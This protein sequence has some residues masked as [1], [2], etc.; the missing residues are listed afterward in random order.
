M[1]GTPRTDAAAKTRGPYKREHFDQNMP[2]RFLAVCKESAKLES[3]LAEAL[4]ALLQCERYI[5]PTTSSA[6]E[7]LIERIRAIRAKHSKT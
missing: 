1:S 2:I 3:D 6:A 7:W 4:A 5:D